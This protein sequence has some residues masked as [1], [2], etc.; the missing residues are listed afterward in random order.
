MYLG[1]RAQHY[2]SCISLSFHH[3]GRCCL[4]GC[5][6]YLARPALD[7][8]AW[9]KLESMHWFGMPQQLP[10]CKFG[11]HIHCITFLLQGPS[12][13]TRPWVD[14]CFLHCEIKLPEA[15][16]YMIVDLR[17]CMKIYD[18]KSLAMD[19][20]TI[21]LKVLIRWHWHIARC[22]KNLLSRHA[23]ISLPS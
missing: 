4:C 12:F 16:D 8:L 14:T 17:C 1:R 9:V 3:L 5:A 6:Y 18:A 21:C 7:V 10:N 13:Y 23:I 11:A 2:F 20:I 22:S 15:A 19:M